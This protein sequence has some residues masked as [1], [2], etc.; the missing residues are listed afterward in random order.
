[1]LLEIDRALDALDQVE[2]G[3]AMPSAYGFD[4]DQRATQP[5]E[6]LEREEEDQSRA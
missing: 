1:L 6:I 5:D 3:A 4:P 2:E